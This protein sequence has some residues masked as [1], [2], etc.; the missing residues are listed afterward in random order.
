MTYM[1]I[2]DSKNNCDQ[3]K[4]QQ[5]NEENVHFKLQAQYVACKNDMEDWLNDCIDNKLDLN[6]DKQNHLT[7]MKETASVLQIYQSISL[8]GDNLLNGKSV[9]VN[10]N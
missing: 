9:Q 6:K 3:V 7:K 4:C 1:K 5:E 2:M 8:P 10:F